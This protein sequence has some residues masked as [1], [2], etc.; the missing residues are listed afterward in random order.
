ML[1]GTDYAMAIAA[2]VSF[3]TIVG[4]LA[5]FMA[6]RHVYRVEPKPPRRDRR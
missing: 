2:V 4:Y 6:A 3:M 5:G 1:D